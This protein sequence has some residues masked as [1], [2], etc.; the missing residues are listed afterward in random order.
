MPV[1]TVAWLYFVGWLLDRR[2][3]TKEPPVRPFKT[4]K[5]RKPLA[6]Q[7]DQVVAAAVTTRI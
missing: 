2:R 1:L 3:D 7:R 5:S 4:N 6:V